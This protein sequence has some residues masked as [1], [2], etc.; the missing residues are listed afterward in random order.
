MTLPRLLR[1]FRS[2]V[3]SLN[4]K[5]SNIDGLDLKSLD[6]LVYI[7]SKKLGMIYFAKKFTQKHYCFNYITFDIYDCINGIYQTSQLK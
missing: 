7:I 2:E 4:A 1:G 6:R 5:L 3:S